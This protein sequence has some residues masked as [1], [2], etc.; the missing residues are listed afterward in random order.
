MANYNV[1]SL[2][3]S[4]QNLTEIPDLS[5]YTKL[6]ILSVSCNNINVINNLPQSLTHFYC[7]HNQITKIENLPPSLIFFYY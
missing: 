2:S 7:D 3:L 4:N 5:L 1:V 6:R